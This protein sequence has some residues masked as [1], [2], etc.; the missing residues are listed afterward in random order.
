MNYEDLYGVRDG[1]LWVADDAQLAVGALALGSVL[2]R[3]E[4]LIAW[5][6]AIEPL[7][8]FL[9]RPNLPREMEHLLPAVNRALGSRAARQT[10]QPPRTESQLDLAWSRRSSTADTIESTRKRLYHARGYLS[11]DIWPEHRK[12]KAMTFDVLL[13]HRTVQRR[14]MSTV[15]LPGGRARVV[16]FLGWT[17]EDQSAIVLYLASAS[18]SARR[19]GDLC[20]NGGSIPRIGLAVR[21]PGMAG[22]HIPNP[23]TTLID[24]PELAVRAA[25]DNPR[26]DFGH[27][28]HCAATAW[29]R[30]FARSVREVRSREATTPLCGGMGQLARN[31]RGGWSLNRAGRAGLMVNAATRAAQLG[32]LVI[33]AVSYSMRHGPNTASILVMDAKGNCAN[34]IVPPLRRGHTAKRWLFARA[35]G[36]HALL[37]TRLGVTRRALAELHA[38]RAAREAL[39]QYEVRDAATV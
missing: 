28:S 33:E 25:L 13:W 9:A 20:F 26:V 36:V 8:S 32:R 29:K 38:I 10:V 24:H 14:G 22:W 6:K 7:P 34:W 16:A 31:D 37:D 4:A 19:W 15:R 39:S 17:I 3:R 35:P 5:R 23:A 18:S 12:C 21:I 30:A 2:S 11:Q 1:A 27:V